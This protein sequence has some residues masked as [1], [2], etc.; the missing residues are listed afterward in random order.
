MQ[1]IVDSQKDLQ[2]IRKELSKREL[3]DTADVIFS[4]GFDGLPTVAFPTKF[5]A[6][7]STTI[8]KL[9]EGR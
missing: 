4:K 2:N 6:N 9:L 7:P 8:N 1:D 5:I 3:K